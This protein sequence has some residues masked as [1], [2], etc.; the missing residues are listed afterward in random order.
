MVAVDAARQKLTKLEEAALQEATLWVETNKASIPMSVYSAVV[1]LVTLRAELA[2][3]KERA[4][5]LLALFRRELGVEPKY[6]L[7]LHLREAA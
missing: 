2:R 4:S 1:L 7:V 5:R 3:T 6:A